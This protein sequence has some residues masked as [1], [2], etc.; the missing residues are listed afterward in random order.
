MKSFKY[1]IDWKDGKQGPDGEV[2]EAWFQALPTGPYRRNALERAI[3]EGFQVGSL[4]HCQEIV[5]HFNLKH[6]PN[7]SAMTG[8]TVYR[9]ASRM[10]C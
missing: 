1:K 2:T 6:D 7:R 9:H 4:D 8:W 3:K 5:R 10:A